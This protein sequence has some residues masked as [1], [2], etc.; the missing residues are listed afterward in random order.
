MKATFFNNGNTMFF[1]DKGEQVPELQQSWF[2]MYIKFLVKQGID[3]INVEYEM[4]DG[5]K[6]E[7]FKTEDSYN[8]RFGNLKK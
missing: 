7:P 1:N 8:W 5:Q 4:P 6:P 3:P 2:L